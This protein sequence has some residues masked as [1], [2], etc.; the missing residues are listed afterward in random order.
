MAEFVTIREARQAMKAG[1]PTAR[2]LVELCAERI[3]RCEADI[4][5]W[6]CFDLEAAR[7]EAERLEDVCR[8]GIER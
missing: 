8:R 3:E 5:A 6:V 2:T 1:R 7:R 4:R